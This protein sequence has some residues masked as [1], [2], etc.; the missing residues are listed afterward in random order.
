M[1]L[2]FSGRWDSQV[3]VLRHRSCL[4]RESLAVILPCCRSEPG[5]AQISFFRVTQ[6]VL[7]LAY[8][9]EGRQGLRCPATGERGDVSSSLT[10]CSALAEV[11]NLLNRLPVL[12]LR[13]YIFLGFVLNRDK[14]ME[15]GRDCR[16]WRRLDARRMS[17]CSG[18]A[19]GALSCWDLQDTALITSATQS[20]QEENPN[21]RA[22]DPD[23]A[24]WKFSAH[25]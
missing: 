4:A 20:K 1:L 6:H 10:A 18:S 9:E 11:M 3:P 21:I 8:G 2:L 7:C 16:P 19:D 24:L 14:K 25:L 5:A 12:Q 17:S 13:C 22:S 23:S 15:A